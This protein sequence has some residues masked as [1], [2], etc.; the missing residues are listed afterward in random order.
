[1]VS[2]FLFIASVVEV[3]KALIVPELRKTPIIET[4]L[5]REFTRTYKFCLYSG[6]FR[7]FSTFA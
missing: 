3:V 1:M 7:L 5:W 4:I 2:R 6:K